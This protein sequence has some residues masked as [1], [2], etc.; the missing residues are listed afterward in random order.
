MGDVLLASTSGDAS[1]ICKRY[2]DQAHNLMSTQLSSGSNSSSSSVTKK[3][4]YSDQEVPEIC[5]NCDKPGLSFDPLQPFA[6]ACVH[7]NSVHD[8]CCLSLRLVNFDLSV[9][10]CE[11]CSSVCVS[12]DG[13]DQFFHGLL[14]PSKLCPFCLILMDS[15]L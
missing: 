4:R 2:A 12:D 9:R 1:P 10:R 13:D 11:M 7:C 3:A 6:S 15:L 14:A 5:L 8:R